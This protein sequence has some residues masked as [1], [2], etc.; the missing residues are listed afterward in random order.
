MLNEVDKLQREIDVLN[1]KYEKG[2][3]DI[4]NMEN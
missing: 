1:R 4:V 3:D 2:K